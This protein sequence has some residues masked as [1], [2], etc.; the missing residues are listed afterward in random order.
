MTEVKSTGTCANNYVL[1]RTWIA[2]DACDNTTVA[3]QRIEVLDC[4]PE[5]D[6][7]IGPDSIV[8]VNANVQFTVSIN[9]DYDTP[10]YQWQF[11]E[12][13]GL[14]WN[15]ILGANESNLNIAATQVSDTGWYRC[16][17]A[18]EIINLYHP[19]CNIISDPVYL[20]VLIPIE[21]SL[22]HI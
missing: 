8:C 21:L 11:S 15:D 22:I 5:V 12:N 7:S 17:V 4:T 14:S 20:N 2:T 1:M 3:S 16:L 6:L 19:D 10:F 9:G 18:N 13:E